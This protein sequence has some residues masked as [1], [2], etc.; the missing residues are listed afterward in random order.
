[1]KEQV[2]QPTLSNRY[3]PSHRHLYL[4]SLKKLEVQDSAYLGYAVLRLQSW[5]EKYYPLFFNFTALNNFVFFQTAR[6]LSFL[7]FAIL[8]WSQSVMSPHVN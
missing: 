5:I 1:M 7:A 4:M 3:P 2:L 6:S 8:F